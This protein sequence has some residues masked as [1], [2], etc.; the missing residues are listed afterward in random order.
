MEEL[1]KYFCNLLI[2]QYKNKPKAKATIEALVRSL[3]ETSDGKVFLLE[4][5][6]AYDL[7]T[8]Q[9][10]QLELLA[11]YIGYDGSLDVINTNYFKLSDTEGLTITPG[12]SDTEGN[13]SGHPLL[14]YSGY[15]Y[16][17]TTL[18]G[19]AGIDFFRKTLLFLSEMKGEVLSLGNLDRLLQKYYGNDLYV[20]EGAKEI[21]YVYDEDILKLFNN[22]TGTVEAFI[23]KYMPRPMGCGFS[24]QF[25]AE[26]YLAFTIDTT[27]SL[28]YTI[29]Y[30][31]QTDIKS[32]KID[33]GDGTVNTYTSANEVPTHTYSQVGEYQIKVMPL[34]GN[35]IPAIIFGNQYRPDNHSNALISIDFNKCKFIHSTVEDVTRFDYMFCNCQNLYYVDKDLFKYNTEAVSFFKTFYGCGLTTIPKDLFK[36]T[37]KASNFGKCFAYN[38]ELNEIP[39]GLFEHLEYEENPNFEK[40]FYDRSDTDKCQLNEHIFCKSNEKNTKFADVVPN[41]YLTFSRG[42]EFSGVQG[43]APDLWNYTFASTPNGRNCFLGQNSTSLTNYS[44]IPNDWGGN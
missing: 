1:I 38:K 9:L 40:C 14:N 4:Y 20:I 33:W 43:T 35:E 22:D 39:N 34:N 32:I 13:Y 27:D 25:Q 11:K 36:E 29:P 31:R 30:D 8:A 18:P 26:K 41:F 17:T 3:F 28:T 6:N 44:N 23:R 12:L 24:I 15:T 10:A 37:T 2:I 19:V 5:Q 42:Y 16:T 7:D 21:T